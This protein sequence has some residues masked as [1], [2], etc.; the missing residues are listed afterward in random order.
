MPLS[1]V[2]DAS[3]RTTALTAT[4][5]VTMQDRYDLVLRALDDQGLASGES[6]FLIDVSGVDA[7]PVEED[8][9]AIAAMLRLLRARF[10]GRVAILNTSAGHATVS[11][12]VALTA[13]APDHIQAFTA[14]HE[15]RAWLAEPLR[16]A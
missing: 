8:V 13:M 14:E 4:G 3:R 11:V 10:G 1:Y 9:G 12:L 15:A 5:R 16:S 6:S 2:Y 7:A